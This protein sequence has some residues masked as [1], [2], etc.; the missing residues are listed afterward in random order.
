MAATQTAYRVLQLEEE[1]FTGEDNRRRVALRRELEIGAFGINA[2]YQAKAGEPVVN[3]HDETSPFAGG[4]EELYLV[5]RGGCTFTVEGDEFAAPAG[6]AVFV[7]DPAAKRKSVATEDGTIVVAIGGKRGEAYRPVPYDAQ[8]GFG[9]AYNE[10]DYEQ[11]IAILNGA[12]EQYPGNAGLTYNL[13][14]MEALVGREDEALAHLEEALVWEPFKE[15]AA[16][17]DD[18]ASLRDKPDFRQL[19]A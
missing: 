2:I 5:V 14:C 4:H 16:N 11:A 19:L 1:A 3:E 12:L 13:A 10:K 7:G 6:A 17:D 18:F 8:T 15:L 9:E